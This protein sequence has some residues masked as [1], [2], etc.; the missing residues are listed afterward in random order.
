MKIQFVELNF[1]NGNISGKRIKIPEKALPFQSPEL[2]RILESSLK[3]FQN[4][5]QNQHY[6][7]GYKA[8]QQYVKAIRET[9]L[10]NIRCRNDKSVLEKAK[11]EAFEK[12]IAA[13]NIGF[14]NVEKNLIIEMDNE[15]TRTQ[16][17]LTKELKVFFIKNPP[18]QF[19]VFQGEIL[20]RKVDHY[21]TYLVYQMKFPQA[22]EIVQ[23]MK[24]DFKY[25]DLTWEDLSDDELLKEFEMKDVLKD[26]IQNIRELKK[27]FT[28]KK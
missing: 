17:R 27:A 26:D 19:K 21:A 11:K 23:G 7:E 8:I 12:E 14:K 13:I 9:Y 25:Y 1:K 4:D 28:I 6:L 15:I 20:E 10:K 18:D 2:K 22:V 16:E 3:I 5:E 24:L